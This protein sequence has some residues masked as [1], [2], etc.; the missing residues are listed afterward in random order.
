MANTFQLIDKATVGAGGATDVTFSSI[1][2]TYTDLYI[3]A[4]VRSTEVDNAS[5]FRV[6]FNNDTSQTVL[7]LRAIG[8]TIASYS[9]SYAQ[10]GYVAAS[11]STTNTFGSVSVYVPNYANGNYKTVIGDIVQASNTTGENY[12][13]MNSKLWSSTSAITSVTLKTGT[14]NLVQYSSFYLYGIKKN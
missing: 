7:E 5:S 3:V 10:T 13:V 6:Y 8:T 4:S 9:V 11:Q 14:G 12:A 2:S 1:P